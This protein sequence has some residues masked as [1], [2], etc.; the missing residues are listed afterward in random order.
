MF[1]AIGYLLQPITNK[2]RGYVIFNSSPWGVLAKQVPAREVG[3]RRVIELSF[4]S[5]MKYITIEE[6]DGWQVSEIIPRGPVVACTSGLK[7]GLT[8]L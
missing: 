6:F 2:E 3:E 5:N 7:S 1:V 4:K 8:T